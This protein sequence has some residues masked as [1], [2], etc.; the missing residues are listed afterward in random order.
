MQRCRLGRH[1]LGQPV[2]AYARRRRQRVEQRELPRLG[3]GLVDDLLDPGREAV[4]GE[5]EPCV[6]ALELDRLGRR[7][8]DL[9]ARAEPVEHPT[10]RRVAILRAFEIDRAGDDQPVDR[11]RHRD[12]VEAQ[13]LGVVLVLLGLRARRRSRRRPSRLPEIGSIT[14]KPKLPSGRTRISFA[15]GRADAVAP[16][17]GDDHDLELEPLRRMDRQQADRVG[18]LLLGDRLELGRADRLLVADHVDEPRDVRAA[19]LLVRAREAHQLAQVRVAALAVPAREHREVVVVRGDDLLAESLEAGARRRGDE[20]LVALLERAH[21][22]L[23]VRRERLGQRALD[24]GVERPPTGMAPDQ[25]DRVVRDADERRS[26][27][28]R[29]RLVVVAVVQEPEVR[30]QVDDLLLAEVA[31]TG[32]AVRRQPFARSADS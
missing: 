20:P 25:D 9:V 23:V 31:A 22:P 6:A 17:V 2:A 10:D 30:E 14:R 19:Q 11:A 5:D 27:H 18:A 16:G 8:L 29:K 21:E 7:A 3:R 12:V 13:P 26:E 4:D 24:T 15:D 28:G 32:R 1:E